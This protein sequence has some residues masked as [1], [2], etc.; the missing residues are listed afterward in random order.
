MIH[1]SPTLPCNLHIASSA[2]T[3]F[4]LSWNFQVLSGFLFLSL[5]IPHL[6]SLI[7]FS[8][9]APSLLPKPAS[10]F[11]SMAQ[12]L[13]PVLTVS[14]LI[15]ICWWTLV[16]T[17]CHFYSSQIK[18]SLKCDFTFLFLSLP[19]TNQLSHFTLL[20]TV[21]RI[22][23]ISKTDGLTWQWHLQASCQDSSC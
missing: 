5:P 3:A 9:S 18:G 4:T 1:W 20:M 12:T 14:T 21:C 22:L 19:S 16:F 15:F 7:C 6:G 23:P 8:C 17:P 11:D 13:L 10:V 2:A